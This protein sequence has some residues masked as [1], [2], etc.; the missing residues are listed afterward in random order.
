VPAARPEGGVPGRRLAYV[1][2]SAF[3]AQASG[4]GEHGSSVG[5][6]GVGC[7]E[8]E[9]SEPWGVDAQVATWRARAGRWEW[10]LAGPWGWH[11]AP[12]CGSR[13]RAVPPFCTLA[14]QATPFE[15]SYVG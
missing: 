5:M 8:L 10:S 11:R 7:V 1:E 3:G 6:R 4:Y 13:G 9:S 14:V 15:W 2:G 12:W